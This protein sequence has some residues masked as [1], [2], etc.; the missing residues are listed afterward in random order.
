MR[1]LQMRRAVALTAALVLLVLT[2]FGV[3]GCRDS[4]RDDAFRSYVSRA[5]T[6]AG[7]SQEESQ[8]LF[9]LLAGAGSSGPVQIESAV[10]GIRADSVA[11]ASR[12]NGLSH[13]DEL[14]GAERELVE[15]L[16]LRRDA[17]TLIAKVLPNALAEA[18]QH[19]AA[20][21]FSAAAEEM[22]ASDVIYAERVVP[23]IQGPV[24]AQ[25]L[26]TPAPPASTFLPDLGWL[27]PATAEQRLSALQ[28]G[29]SAASPGNHRLTLGAVTVSP[30][31]DSLTQGTAVQIPASPSISLNVGVTNQGASTEH[32]AAV[33]VVISGGASP[34]QADQQ[35]S[36]LDAGA[37]QTVTVPLPTLPPAGTPVTV[38][39]SVQGAGAGPTSAGKASYQAVFSR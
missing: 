37:S 10:E 26:V 11:L 3:K 35:I 15:A 9:R 29:G 2:V 25:G 18:G 33:R 34:I 21:R 39:V 5:A 22:L 30:S 1:T 14:A 23:D 6:L 13:P 28:S 32:A 16:G 38:N 19:A 20:A 12:A 7:Q 17:L 27:S 8:A 24:A 36:S 4:A 31:G